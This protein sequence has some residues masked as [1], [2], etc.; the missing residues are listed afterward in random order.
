MHTDP[1]PRWPFR[2]V[3]ALALASGALFGAGG[4]W[5][6]V[7]RSGWFP[8][9]RAVRCSAIGAVCGVFAAALWCL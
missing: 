4:G 7:W 3:V 8:L 6:A 2:I 9:G 5:A 1:P